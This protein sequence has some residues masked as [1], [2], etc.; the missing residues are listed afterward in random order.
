MNLR[1]FNIPGGGVGGGG[2]QTAD[3]RRSVHCVSVPRFPGE[4]VL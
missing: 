3:S 2:P 4:E 1:S